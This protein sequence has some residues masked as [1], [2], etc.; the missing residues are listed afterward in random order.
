MRIEDI[1][2]VNSALAQVARA[3]KI[4]HLSLSRDG[5]AAIQYADNVQVCFEYISETRR[6]YLYAAIISF[7]ANTE[8]RLALFEKLLTCKFLHT[9]SAAGDFAVL[10]P[11]RQTM[12]QIWLDAGT[13]TAVQLNDAIN[14]LL[15][16]R[17]QLATELTNPSKH[18]AGSNTVDG[19]A[20]LARRLRKLVE[21]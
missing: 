16:K 6:L 2:K 13:I 10:P 11:T 8:E 15:D 5:T 17:H 12:Y 7:P 19:K 1:L 18:N 4:E 20:T 21:T 3:D 9:G 14:S